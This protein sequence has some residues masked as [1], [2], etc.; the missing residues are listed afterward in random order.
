MSENV[1][2]DGDYTEDTTT[3]DGA[4]EWGAHRRG[5]LARYLAVSD[6]GG[7]A[8]RELHAKTTHRH[9]GVRERRQKRRALI[10]VGHLRTWKGGRG[11]LTCRYP[12]LAPTECLCTSAG[13]WSEQNT[14][15]EST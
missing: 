5:Q 9:K 14:S 15:R 10:V 13:C 3:L 8:S 7:G 1:R 6:L 12:S 4:T 11:T 2:P